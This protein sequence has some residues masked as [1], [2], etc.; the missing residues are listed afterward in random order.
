[1]GMDSR[2]NTDS[3]GSFSRLLIAALGQAAFASPLPVQISMQLNSAELHDRVNR[4]TARCYVLKQVM[5]LRD[6]DKRSLIQCE[7]Y[8]KSTTGVMLG[9]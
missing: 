6:A 9:S 8:Q 4:G 5:H 1:M 2:A 7:Y 3:L